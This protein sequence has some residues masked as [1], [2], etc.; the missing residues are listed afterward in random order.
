MEGREKDGSKG[1][2]KERSSGRLDMWG[3]LSHR[4]KNIFAIRARRGWGDL[5]FTDVMQLA[6][7]QFC[8]LFVFTVCRSIYCQ[9]SA[10][11]L[12]NINSV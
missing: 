1:R 2:H 8:S 10:I 9:F 11:H 7:L 4:V 12:Q 5:C 3:I 6:A